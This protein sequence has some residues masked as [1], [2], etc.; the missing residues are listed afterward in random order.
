[1]SWI[2]CAIDGKPCDLDKHMK[3]CRNLVSQYDGRTFKPGW[4][5]K[6]GHRIARKGKYG[7]QREG[8]NR[9]GAGETTGPQVEIL[10]QGRARDSLEVPEQGHQGSSQGPGENRDGNGKDDKKDEEGKA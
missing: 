9:K 10:E 5:G 1:M 3:Q 8:D 4:T 7:V 6:C 2:E